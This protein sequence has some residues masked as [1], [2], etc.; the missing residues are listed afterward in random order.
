MIIAI[1]NIISWSSLIIQLFLVI[2]Y[3]LGVLFYKF[4]KSATNGQNEEVPSLNTFDSIEYF[5]DV[6]INHNPKQDTE[7]ENFDDYS[8][9]SKEKEIEVNASESIDENTK[10]AVENIE[11]KPAIMEEKAS[12]EIA[13][14]L[15]DEYVYQSATPTAT[16][17]D[18]DFEQTTFNLQS[19]QENSIT[20]VDEEDIKRVFQSNDWVVRYP[21][22]N[23]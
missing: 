3:S 19:E 8:A 18:E 11:F 9:F 23:L 14:N 15:D 22:T 12:T 4:N 5:A 17:E 20:M 2:L 13:E 6:P 16:I 10:I 21:K 7:F 1:L